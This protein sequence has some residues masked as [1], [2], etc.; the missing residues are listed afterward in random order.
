M[1][2]SFQFFVTI[3]FQES[4]IGDLDGAHGLPNAAVKI[5][6]DNGCRRNRWRR[7]DGTA[8]GGGQGENDENRAGDRGKDKMDISF[9]KMV[10]R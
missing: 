6:A 9:H 7:G 8:H 5:A 2:A 10:E 3:R 4:L 1:H